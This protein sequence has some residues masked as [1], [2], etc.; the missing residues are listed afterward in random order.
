MCFRAAEKNRKN[1]LFLCHARAPIFLRG[2]PI[3]HPGHNDDNSNKREDRGDSDYSFHSDRRFVL[4][5]DSGIVDNDDRQSPFR[6]YN[7]LAPNPDSPKLECVELRGWRDLD[8]L[9]Y[10]KIL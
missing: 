4:E 1:F 9:P 6:A 8:R 3:E 5:R 10:R 2:I 7:S